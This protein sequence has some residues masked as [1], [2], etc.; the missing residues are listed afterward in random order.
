VCVCVCVGRYES[1]SELFITFYER[2]HRHVGE[3]WWHPARGGKP[4]FF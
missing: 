4:K 3:I 2:L 1:T